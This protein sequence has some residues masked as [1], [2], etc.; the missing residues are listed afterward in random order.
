MPN[1]TLQELLRGRGAHVD[2][3]ACVAGLDSEAAGRRLP[4][5]E[6]TIWELVCHMNYW[7][8]YE[9]RSI[10]RAGARYPVHAAESWPATAVPP[11]RT[12]G[13]KPQDGS[14]AWSTSSHDWARR[15]A[16]EGMGARIVHQNKGESLEDVLWQM[17]A[18]NSYHTG[19]VALLRRAFGL[20]GRRRGEGIRGRR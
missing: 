4:G 11:P 8:E 15:A 10:G 9:L 17:A 14:P 2:P 19:Q 3:V 7:M 12:H 5:A 20:P 1:H 6:H 13:G 16:V 18:H